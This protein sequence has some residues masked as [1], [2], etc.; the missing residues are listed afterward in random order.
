MAKK[1]KIELGDLVKDEITGFE[2]IVTGQHKW[3]HGCTRF[4]VQPRELK[5]GKAIEPAGFDEPQLILLKKRS[6]LKVATT[7][8]T[9][10][11]RDEKGLRRKEPVR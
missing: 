6:E 1:N 11:P 5:D 4:S 3:L 7:D 10:G 8:K 2:G 9:G